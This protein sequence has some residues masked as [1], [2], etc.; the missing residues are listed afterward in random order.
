MPVMIRQINGDDW[1]LFVPLR[2]KYTTD[3]AHFVG[4]RP[5]EAAWGEAEWRSKL[6]KPESYFVGA[7]EGAAMVG[8]GAF[9]V[10]D[11]QTLEFTSLYVVPAARGKGAGR[12]LMKAIMEKAIEHPTAIT[13]LNCHEASNSL[14]EAMM[15]K[16]GFAFDYEEFN[17]Q[18]YPGGARVL[19]YALDLTPLKK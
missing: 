1:Q 8:F 5:Q 7:F 2:Q 19:H 10:V 4:T 3:E 12:A 11:P 13:M 17:T 14:S 9:K 18:Y 6:D 15:K 16:A